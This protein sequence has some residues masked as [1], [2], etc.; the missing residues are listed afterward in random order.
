[1]PTTACNLACTY[2]YAASDSKKRTF[3]QWPVAKQAIDIAYQN[4]VKLKKGKF[5]LS[6]HGGGEPTLP[7]EFFIKAS[8]YAR[9]LDPNCAISVTTN[10]VW[11]YDFTQ[12]AL[13]FLTEISI[14]IDGNEITQNRQRP[15]NQGKGTFSRVMKTIK[16]I[17]KRDISYGIRMTVTKE[18]LPEL[19]S[20]VEFFCS[21]TK[22]KSFQVEAVYNQGR[23]IGAGL[24]IEDVDTFV[25]IFMDVHHYAKDRGKSV[26]YSS[27]RP[28]LITNTFCT[29]TS[30][31][32]I[33]TTDGELTACY[34]VFDRS[35]ILSEDFIIGRIDLTEG[36]V[37]YPGKREN[38]LK[39]IS[40]NRIACETC[41][42]YYHCAG[43]CPPKAFL[44]HLSKDKFR[45]SITRAITRELIL[46]RIEEYDGFWFGNHPLG[47]NAKMKIPLNDI[48][49]K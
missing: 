7:R 33:V 18:S 1:M 38:L 46:D 25:E 31:A 19:P 11:D 15:D 20:N 45:C 24:A 16:E 28:H 22:C 48:E 13:N 17:E 26:H 47:R 30:N 39:K 2:C 40:D 8:E 21:Q 23:A 5:A 49:S 42:C 14:S 36:M 9:E 6:F 41:F 37:L 35:H 34:E 44:S 27:A 10:A 43:D 32:L 3:L 12:K 4:S 29:A